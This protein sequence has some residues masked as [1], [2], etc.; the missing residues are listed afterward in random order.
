[1]VIRRFAIFMLGLGAVAGSA[2]ATTTWYCNEPTSCGANTSAAFTTATSSLFPVGGLAGFIAGGLQSGSLE[3][4]D[5]TTGVEFFGFADNG[6]S[7]GGANALA[8]SGTTLQASPGGLIELVLPANILAVEMNISSSTAGGTSYCVDPAATFGRNDCNSVV[9]VTSPSDVEFVGLAGATY[10][11][12]WVGSQ[13]LNT[14]TP[15]IA[16]FEIFTS[17]SPTPEGPT[18]LLI[19]TGLIVLHLFHRRRTRVAR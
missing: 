2:R 14:Q 9:V 5:S 8:V 11:T 1:M 10:T 15:V 4:I 16:S 19:G 13:T 7:S 18:M 6:G 12:V 3:Y 17:Q